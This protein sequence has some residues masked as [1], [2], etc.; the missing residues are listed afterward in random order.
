MTA[1]FRKKR[2]KEEEKG[3]AVTRKKRQEEVESLPHR[4]DLVPSSYGHTQEAHDQ[5][6]LQPINVCTSS[7]C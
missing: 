7:R 1:E 3:M 4:Q 5:S 6:S 2:E